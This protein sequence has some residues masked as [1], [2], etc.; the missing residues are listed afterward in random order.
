M[1]E[2]LQPAS[3]LALLLAILERQ[4]R[5][6]ALTSTVRAAQGAVERL[7]V[8]L[9]GLP[10]ACSGQVL[11]AS[12]RPGGDYCGS[13]P[14]EPALAPWALGEQ[15]ELWPAPAPEVRRAAVEQDCQASAHQGLTLIVE[16]HPD[17]AAALA[18]LLEDSGRQVCVAADS[19]EAMAVL[20]SG[21]AIAAVI[22]D[23]GLPGAFSGLEVLE[24]ARRQLPGAAL[25]L[26]TGDGSPE[27]AVQARRS[28]LCLLRKPLRAEELLLALE[29]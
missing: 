19:V 14:A 16:D 4:T 1:H 24:F 18:Q 12:W 5:D 29:R 6:P 13:E 25:V 27:I 11:E 26:T 23:L 17:V 7:G 21:V 10:L 8:L 22:S 20:G 3:S 28:G 15:A 9:P 2:L